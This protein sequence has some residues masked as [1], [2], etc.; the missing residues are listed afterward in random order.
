MVERLL[1]RFSY[2][3]PFRPHVHY[4]PALHWMNDP[5]GLVYDD[6]EYHLFY[7]YNPFGA[8]WV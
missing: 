8:T 2:I 6:G 7:Q 1:P 4:T 5:I 3:E